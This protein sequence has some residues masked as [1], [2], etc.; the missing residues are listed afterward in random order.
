MILHQD[1]QDN[2]DG[3]NISEIRDDI[4]RVQS[5]VQVGFDFDGF[6]QELRDSARE[7][8][9]IEYHTVKMKWTIKL[10]PTLNDVTINPS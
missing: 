5:E 9:A 2:G 4:I 1:D 10:D 7:S 3:K 8:R 6:M